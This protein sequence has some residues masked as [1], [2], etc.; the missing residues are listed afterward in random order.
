MSTGKT[1]QRSETGSGVA[2][3]AEGGAVGGDMNVM[4]LGGRVTGGELAREL[5]QVFLDAR[6][7]GDARFELRLA[8]T[9]E[10]EGRKARHT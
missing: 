4:C 6:F 5:V 9:E 7:E 2:T 10:L 1:C 8:K 3:R